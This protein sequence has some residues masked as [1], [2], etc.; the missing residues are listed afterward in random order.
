MSIRTTEHL[1]TAIRTRR[2]QLKLTQSDL[3][4]TCGTGLRFIV[5][6]EKGKPTC[7]IG[8]TL[9]VLQ[10]LGLAI[11]IAPPG[12]AAIGGSKL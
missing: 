11:E 8:K 4:M 9:T 1:G 7:H 12:R 10:S 6:L 2:K 3:A 5:D